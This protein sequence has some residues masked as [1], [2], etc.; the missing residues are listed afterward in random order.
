MKGSV[1]LLFLAILMSSALFAQYASFSP[2]LPYTYVFK[3]DSAD[4]ARHYLLD[5]IPVF[6]HKLDSF[7][8]YRPKLTPGMYA[9]VTY[10][11]PRLEYEI[12]A[13]PFAR[14]IV[15]AYNGRVELILLDSSF[16]QLSDVSFDLEGKIIP[17]DSAC[18]CYPF[19]RNRK[20]RYYYL[21]RGEAFLMGIV[22]GDKPAYPPA[23]RSVPAGRPVVSYGYFLLNQPKYQPGDSVKMKAYVLNTNGKAYTSSLKL[24]LI[25]QYQTNKPILL[26]T[27]K[28]QSRGAYVYQ[29]KLADTLKL[30]QKYTLELENQWGDRLQTSHFLIEAYKLRNSSYTAQLE[31]DKL[32]KKEE[33]RFQVSAR[34]ANGL[35]LTDARVKLRLK[36]VSYADFYDSIQFIPAEWYHSLLEKTQDLEINS[37][38]EIVVPV[39]SLPAMDMQLKAELSFSNAAGELKKEE[40]MLSILQK[41]SYASLTLEDYQLK[42]ALISYGKSVSHK[43]ILVG[44]NNGTI[45]VRDTVMVP[46]TWRIYQNCDAYQLLDTAGNLLASLNLPRLELQSLITGK[47]THDSIFIQSNNPAQLE[48]YY[49]I[50]KDDML[51]KW[52]NTRNLN[53]V[54]SDTSSASYNVFHSLVYRC[55]KWMYESVFSFK[56]RELIVKTNLPSQI[57]PGQSIALDIQVKDAFRKPVPYS[58]LTAF[59]VNAQFEDFDVPELKSFSSEK[60]KLLLT[61]NTRLIYWPEFTKIQSIYHPSYTY[62]LKT[63]LIKEGDYRLR[64]PNELFIKERLALQKNQVEVV[65]ILTGNGKRITFYSVDLDGIPLVLE[66]ENKGSNALLIPKGKHQLSLRTR[67]AIFTLP[68]INFEDSSRYVLAFDTLCLP[69]GIQKQACAVQQAWS[70]DELTK[71]RKHILVLDVTNRASIAEGFYVVQRNRIAKLTAPIYRERES[72]SSK[73]LIYSGLFEEDSMELVLDGK[74]IQ[75][76]RFESGN[77]YVLFNNRLVIENQLPDSLEYGFRFFKTNDESFSSLYD[78]FNLEPYLLPVPLTAAQFGFQKKFPAA[79]ERCLLKARFVPKVSPNPQLVQVDIKPSNQTELSNVLFFN[80][81]DKL[82]SLLNP[83]MSSSYSI[84]SFMLKPGI[85][86]MYFISAYNTVYKIS[87][88]RIL[89]NGKTCI[90]LDSLYFDKPC[91]I[92]DEVRE[93]SRQLHS[94]YQLRESMQVSY[95]KEDYIEVREKLPVQI[96]ASEERSPLVSGF[97]FDENG[98]TLENVIITLEQQ[99]KVKGIS[100][101]DK[102]GSFIVRDINAGNYQMRLTR[103]GSCITLINSIQLQKNRLHSYSVRLNKCGFDGQFGPGVYFGKRA[104]SELD[105]TIT[106]TQQSRGN[107]HEN[108]S[109][110]YLNGTGMLKGR[111]VDMLTKSPLDYVSIALIRNGVKVL[112]G[113]S[114]DDGEFL[115]RNLAPGDYTLQANYIGYSQTIIKGILIESDFVRHV[116]FTMQGSDRQLQEVVITHKKDLVDRGGVRGQSYTSKEVMASP[117]RSV[118]SIAYTTMGVESRAGYNTP[119]I[120]GSRVEGTA[121]YIDGIRVSEKG[122]LPQNAIDANA[123]FKSNFSANEERQ[124]MI[125]LASDAT[126]KN[127]RSVFRDYAFWVPNL[128]T[129]KQGEAHVSIRFPDNIT[130]WDTWILAMNEHFQSGT[131]KWQLRAYKPL[132]ASLY[133]P[134]FAI[135]GDQ[136]HIKGK[137]SNYTGEEL[138]VHTHFSLGDSL[139]KS[140]S[141][142][143]QKGHTE[144]VRVDVSSTDTLA[145]K[146]GLKADGNYADGET[147]LLP[148]LPAGIETNL[149]QQ[150]LLSQDSVWKISTE[151]SGTYELRVVHGYSQLLREEI[152]RLRDYQY[153]CVEQT[154]SKMNALLV[155]KALCRLMN[156]SFGDEN[157]IR[158]CIRKLEAQQSGNGSFGWFSSSTPETWLTFYVVKSLQEAEK[159]GYETRVLNKG[160]DYFRSNLHKFQGTEK[161]RALYVLAEAR[162]PLKYEELLGSFIEENLALLDRLMLTAIKQK[163]GLPHFSGFLYQHIAK[164]A[165]GGIFWNLPYESMF[166]NRNTFGPMA[167]EVLKKDGADSAFLAGLRMYYFNERN[168]SAYL[169]R[170]TLESAMVLQ[171]MAKD[172]AAAENSKFLPILSLNGRALGNR[173]PMRIKLDTNFTYKLSNKGAKA[174]ALISNKVFVEKPNYDSSSFGIKTYFVQDSRQV[175][176]LKSDMELEYHI[177]LSSK[178]NQEFLL[179]QIPIPASCIYSEKGNPFG[180]DEVEYKKDR[181]LLYFRRMRAGTKH[182]VIRLE[183]RFKGSYTLL[184]V[185]VENMYDAQIKGNNGAMKLEIK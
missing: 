121:Y 73:K 86:D 2:K 108:E 90:S 93:L 102:T 157:L 81:E 17:F 132:S 127:N 4:V 115:F 128:V 153:G 147:F 170:N 84:H 167:Y 178:K 94:E 57:Y 130:R 26:A 92:L 6:K 55:H 124:R 40:F 21:K 184:P 42:A 159:Q 27:L 35:P 139:I 50:Y 74:P 85:Y 51:I 95:R 149:F 104:L 171:A 126:V 120:R 88:M 177:E 166:Q 45:L 142:R 31:R 1:L 160:L 116:N 107:T 12:V 38:T 135:K 47:R 87:N 117:V 9:L 140:D 96:S 71:I 56:E 11:E 53:Y 109:P 36:L 15:N 100:F 111:V 54:L 77:T 119:I 131:N 67:S 118:N 19:E 52:G 3:L 164:N 34:D 151:S 61:E 125:Q 113:L 24:Y 58:N 69:A 49:R 123:K 66:G 16:R 39:D 165:E 162:E 25:P 134:N 179:V 112:S 173:F 60:D 13:V 105:K 161:L 98:T 180:A 75:K 175:K 37:L 110:V 76:L 10:R 70:K 68:S 163:L 79:D 156:D 89:A 32:Y 64:Y 182:L 136:I 22:S 133:I 46:I 44:L 28:P 33:I 8:G 41:P 59:G 20:K 185:Q 78:T 146:Y 83:E 172:I 30:D 62:L 183:P 7:T 122:N 138:E 91:Y 158:T 168:F 154:S 174:Q 72:L 114:D 5:S 14:P 150:K 99:G 169:Q 148:V 48:F 155:E 152:G 103:Y 65:P 141:V 143:I 106:T 29:F 181:V 63:G 145:L 97:V 137:L 129:D 43:A 82:E 176:Q 144:S 80:K 23:P 18:Q 101:S